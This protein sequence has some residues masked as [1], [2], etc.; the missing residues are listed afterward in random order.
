MFRVLAVAAA[1]RRRGTASRAD[2]KT[3]VDEDRPGKPTLADLAIREVAE[4]TGKS[5]QRVASDFDE[6]GRRFTLEASKFLEAIA[7]P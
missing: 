2:L 1:R 7:G 3:I 5:T 6:H 4:A